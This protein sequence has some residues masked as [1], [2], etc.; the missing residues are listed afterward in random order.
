VERVAVAIGTRKRV[1]QDLFRSL[2]IAGQAIG[3]PLDRVA[4]SGEELLE[5]IQ[6]VGLDTAQQLRIT[7][8]A[9]RRRSASRSVVRHLFSVRRY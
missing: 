6:I 9:G 1:L 3:R 8:F 7:I 2:T 4:V 5:G